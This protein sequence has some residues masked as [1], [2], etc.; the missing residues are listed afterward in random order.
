MMVQSFLR[1]EVYDASCRACLGIGGPIDHAGNTSVEYG[2]YAHRA[3]LQG[4]V[5]RSAA[6][7]VVVH[8]AAGGPD[9]LDFSVRRRVRRGYRPIPSF[10][11]YLSIQHYQRPYR[12]FSV[13]TGP[14]RE[15]Q[16]ATHERI[17]GRVHLIRIALLRALCLITI[18]A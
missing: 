12:Y 10:A 13:S 3:R 1:E 2:P 7:T 15:L 16:C 17:V 18:F 5:K 6:Q 11:G 14:L 9:R 4:D 8:C